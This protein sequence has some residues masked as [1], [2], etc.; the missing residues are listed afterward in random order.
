MTATLR[1]RAG[2]EPRIA[3][4]NSGVPSVNNVSGGLTN[5]PPANGIV[6][7]LENFLAQ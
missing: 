6:Q 2:Q 7:T 1:S 4:G 5:V 3:D